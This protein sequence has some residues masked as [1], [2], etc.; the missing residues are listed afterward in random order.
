MA[1]AGNEARSHLLWEDGRTDGRTTAG[2][3]LQQPATPSG[4]KT[5][6]RLSAPCR[7]VIAGNEAHTFQDPVA[8]VTQC[9]GSAECRGKIDNKENREDWFHLDGMR[10]EREYGKHNR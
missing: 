6:P 2:W 10:L 4:E 7:L 8:A 1:M 9:V 5:T 3:I